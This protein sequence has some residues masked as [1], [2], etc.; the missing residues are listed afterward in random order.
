MLKS[1]WNF[2]SRRA[3]SPAAPAGDEV[4]LSVA[5]LLVEAARADEAYTDE[6]KALIE[7][8]LVG[9]FGVRAGDAA[10]LR[11][12]AEA[13]QQRASDLHRFTRIAKTLSSEKKAALMEC[14]WRV[15]LSD[16]ARDCWE[17]A[18]MRRVCG[19][20][21]VSDVDSGLARRRVEACAAQSGI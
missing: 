12:K 10:A 7:T 4:T 20:L 9:A 11:A 21:Y 15:V 3:A 5:A 8:A 2:F 1:R 13:A 6:E 16:G 17:D 14:L 18:L 19:L